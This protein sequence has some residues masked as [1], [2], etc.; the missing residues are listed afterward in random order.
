MI[1]FFCPDEF[2]YNRSPK[3]EDAEE[4]AFGPFREIQ[5]LVDSHLA[6]IIWP[7]PVVYTGGMIPTL[8]RP[9]VDAGAFDLF[10]Y[11]I[12]LTPF[13]A[14]LSNGKQHTISFELP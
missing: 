13:A 11:Q 2:W 6:G 3:P 4:K 5:I 12:D 8:W 14:L 10:A 9:L 7:V 1:Y